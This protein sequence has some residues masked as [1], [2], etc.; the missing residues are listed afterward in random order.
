MS[1][2][3]KDNQD[4]T[5]FSNTETQRNFLTAEEYPEGPYG[6]STGKEDPV[7]NKETPWKED[8][9]FYSNF[10][11]EGRNF[12][13]DVPRKFPGAHQTHD[14]DGKETEKPYDDA[15]TDY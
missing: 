1:S 9:Q 13:E 2:N 6:S 8:Q 7:Q 15:P 12:H 3:K 11:Y 14:E 4:Y 10:V 5:D